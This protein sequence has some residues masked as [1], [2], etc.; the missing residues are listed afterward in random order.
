MAN[1]RSHPINAAGPIDYGKVASVLIAFGLL[2][3]LTAWIL[4]WSAETLFRRSLPVASPAQPGPIEAGERFPSRDYA[5]IG[6]LSVRR[7]NQ[8]LR[9]SVTADVPLNGWSFVEGEVLDADRE[10][11]LSFGKELWHESGRDSD[12]PWNEADESYEMKLTIPHPGQYYLNIKAQGERL[13]TNITVS[14]NRTYGSSIPHLVFGIC[15]LLGGLVLNEF[16][17]RTV[18]RIVRAFS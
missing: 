9:V 10:Y 15:A 16:A 18:V 6:P 8:V 7:A 11:L 3:L 2:G 5:L 1:V 17:N 4:S 12:G 14:V 13:P